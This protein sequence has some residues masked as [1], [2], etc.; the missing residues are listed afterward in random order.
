[1]RCTFSSVRRLTSTLSRLGVTR[2]TAIFSRSTAGNWL[3]CNRRWLDPLNRD[4]RQIL[5]SNYDGL[6]ASF[7]VIATMC[8]KARFILCVMD[9][10]VAWSDRIAESSRKCPAAP[11][12]H[13]PASA[14]RRSH[15]PAAGHLSAHAWAMGSP[16]DAPF[17]AGAACI[18]D[19]SSTA[20][21]PSSCRHAGSSADASPYDSA[22]DGPARGE[23]ARCAAGLNAG[24]AVDL[25]LHEHWATSV[26]A[27]RVDARELER[28][29]RSTSF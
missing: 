11:K 13:G 23:W 1:M 25:S 7:P 17:G 2:L 18:W 3:F 28:F 21:S 19:I 29:G 27:L 12:P 9:V 14:R 26:P 16:D 15:P 8:T 10:H 4:E 24:E 6:C 20:A 5:E 22:D